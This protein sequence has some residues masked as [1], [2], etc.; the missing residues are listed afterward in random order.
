MIKRFYGFNVAVKDLEAASKKFSEVLGIDPVPHKAEDFAFKRIRGVDLKIG[1]IVITLIASDDP[2]TSVAS[3]IEKKGEGVFLVSFEV[4]DI[5]NDIKKLETKGCQMVVD[6]PLPYAH[7][8]AAWGYPKS[9]YGV[10]IE[11]IQPDK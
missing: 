3:F 4:D 5:E 10:Q 6:K 11:L 9:M 7:G 8:K 2:D 1:D